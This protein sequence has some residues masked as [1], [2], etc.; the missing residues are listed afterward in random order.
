MADYAQFAAQEAPCD[1][2]GFAA[3]QTACKSALAHLEAGAKLMAWAEDAEAGDAK[4]DDL[5]RMI[6]AA[7]NTIA[8]ADIDA[9]EL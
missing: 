3:H 8:T 9:D 1:A 5:A 4:D 6:T 2:K 7:E